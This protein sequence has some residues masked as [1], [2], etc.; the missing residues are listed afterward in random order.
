VAHGRPQAGGRRL[1]GSLTRS[2]QRSAGGRTP[3]AFLADQSSTSR[4]IRTARCR[5]GSSW[6]TARPEPPPSKLS[7]L[8]QARGKV[9]WTRSWAGRPGPADPGR[10]WPGIR[11]Q[12]TLAVVA[13]MPLALSEARNA[14]TSAT[15]ARCGGA[16]EHGHAG[17]HALDG[18]GF[19]VPS[20]PT[21][22]S[23]SLVRVSTTPALWMPRT[24]T[25]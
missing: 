11:P 3:A 13:V 6:T 18:L 21:S 2:G 23:S 17:D 10:A 16:A 1:P 20:P 15:W 19:G 25:P 8:R 24:R 14:A 22:S 4:R 12:V 9:S 5:G 7:R